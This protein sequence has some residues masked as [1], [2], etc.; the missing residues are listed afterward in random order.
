[1]HS[2]FE[3]QIVSALAIGQFN[4]LFPGFI[5]THELPFLRHIAAA[6]LSLS[7]EQE[8]QK[9]QEQR[10]VEEEDAPQTCDEGAF[11][12]L[13]SEVGPCCIGGRGSPSKGKEQ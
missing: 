13:V 9:E 8:E 6:G 4:R 10:D 2:F 11:D 7:P 1:M 3:N 12:G 5:A